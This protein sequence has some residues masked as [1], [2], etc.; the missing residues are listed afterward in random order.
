MVA[1]PIGNLADISARALAVFEAAD[2]VCAE[3]TRVTGQLLSAYGIRAKRLVSLREHNE[4]SMAEQVIRWLGEGQIVAQ[5]SDAGTPAVS[6]P[7]ARLV[8]A[9]RA[10]GHPVRPLPGASAVIAA[11]SASGFTAP[12]FLFHG[13]LPSKSGERRKTLQQWQDAPH[14]TICYEAP[15]RIV[16]ALAD[17]VAELG[18]ERRVMLSRELTKTFET[19]Q[20]LPAAELLEWVKADSNQQRGEIALIID[21]AP[22]VEASDDALPAETV[23]VLQLLAAE[24]PTKQ[25]ATLAAQITGA[26]RKQLYDHALKLKKD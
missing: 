20:A 25:A 24:L 21:A 5:V 6:D 9:V 2:V 7:G 8:E 4:R 12:T 18:P 22:A 26:N 3:D 13:F 19:F 23:R 1:T 15:H 14:L 10:A 11:L 16:D 17:I